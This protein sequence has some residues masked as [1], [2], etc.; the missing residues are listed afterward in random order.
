VTHWGFDVPEGVD[1]IQWF[2]LLLLREDDMPPE[3]RSN[4]FIVTARRLLGDYNKTVVDCIAD[5]L[6]SLWCHTIKTITQARGDSVVS[7]L[8]FN[9]VITIPAI[10]KDYAREDMRNAVEKAGILQERPSVGKTVLSFVPE[11]EAAGLASLGV[12]RRNLQSGD[13]Y[14]ICDAGGGTVVC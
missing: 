4:D 12:R 5:Y 13:V 11:P 9:V 2:K 7:N 10:W 8:E 14:V 1:S 6:R 3:I